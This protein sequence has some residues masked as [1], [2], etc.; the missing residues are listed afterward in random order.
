[1][2][3]YHLQKSYQ[4]ILIVAAAFRVRIAIA[5]RIFIQHRHEHEVHHLP[6]F[7][8]FLASKCHLVALKLILTLTMVR[9]VF[10]LLLPPFI[11]QAALHHHHMHH[12][13]K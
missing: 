11:I 1:M 7:T 13:S 10:V 9:L 12:V 2:S 5:P 6:L 3:K 4:Y 8:G